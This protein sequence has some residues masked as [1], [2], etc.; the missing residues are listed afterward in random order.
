[1]AGLRAAPTGHAGAQ[2]KRRQRPL[3]QPAVARGGP[4]PPPRAMSSS[5]FS[6]S[7]AR[8]KNCRGPSEMSRETVP[9]SPPRADRRRWTQRSPS[10]A[11][12]VRKETGRRD[13]A[14]SGGYW[15]A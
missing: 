2:Q 13:G 10:R 1:M 9:D 12:G 14:S 6:S 15:V 4:S 11:W 3:R 8:R 5:S 7:T